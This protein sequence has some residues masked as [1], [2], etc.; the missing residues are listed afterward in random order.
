MVS[1]FDP[2]AMRNPQTGRMGFPDRVDDLPED[3]L[4]PSKDT[5]FAEQGIDTPVQRTRTAGY[6]NAVKR[7]DYGVGLLID[8]LD[9][10]GIESE[11]LLIF[12]GDHGPPFARGKTT[13]YEFGLRVPLLLRLTGQTYGQ[14]AAS[15]VS[16]VDIYPTILQALG[17]DIPSPIHGVS[18]LPVISNPD[19]QIHDY[20]YSEWEYHGRSPHFP[21]RAI[22]DQQYK[23]IHNL[24]FDQAAPSVAIDGD[25]VYFDAVQEPWETTLAGQAFA[26]FAEPPE[27]ELF[28]LQSDPLEQVDLSSSEAHVQ[29]LNRLKKSLAAE[30]EKIHD[31]KI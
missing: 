16:T 25:R 8:A 20:L 13:N 4:Q 27:F 21:R 30:I 3:L 23:L 11:T 17:I 22:R 24:K 10:Y 18:L 9:E 29:V 31:P 15:M 14:V 19:I 7:L 5:L 26:R 1:F 2:H 6:L 28:D 12:V